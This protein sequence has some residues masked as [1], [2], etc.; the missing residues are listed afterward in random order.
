MRAVLTASFPTGPFSE[1]LCRDPRQRSGTFHQDG[2]MACPD[3]RGR[4]RSKARQG[5]C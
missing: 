1:W 3:T 4:V 2:W 5:K